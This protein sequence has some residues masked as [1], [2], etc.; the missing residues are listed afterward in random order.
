[1]DRIICSTRHDYEYIRDNNIDGWQDRWRQLLEGRFAVIDGDLYEDANAPI[2]KLGFTV[3]EVVEA[4]G[5]V[6]YTIREAE[7]FEA[8]P[9]QYQLT[10]GVWVE[11][12]G[13]RAN[14]DAAELTQAIASKKTEVQQ[15]KCRLRDSGIV[16]NGVLFDTDAAAQSAYTK[17]LLA[18]QINPEYEISDWKASDGVFV[19]MNKALVLQVMM[20][21]GSRESELT[22]RQK[23]KYAEID[24]LSIEDIYKYDA[25]YNWET[26]Q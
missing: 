1:M 3:E 17:T 5:F 15:E 19:K 7:W 25:T 2:F 24:A 22:T 16:I 21:S 13:W 14:R 18:C 9:D 11:I 10:D 12:E 20:A 6:G 4:I 8:H 23:E 26:I